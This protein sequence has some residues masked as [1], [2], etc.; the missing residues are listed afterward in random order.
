MQ[1]VCN[2]PERD[3][4]QNNY[5]LATMTFTGESLHKHF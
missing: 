4:E 3:R 2:T 1:H 5:S